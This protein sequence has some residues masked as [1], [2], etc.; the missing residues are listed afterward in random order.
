MRYF[1][2]NLCFYV[3]ITA[4]RDTVVSLITKNTKCFFF[5]IK[6]KQIIFSKL[7]NIKND[8]YLIG[9]LNGL[10]QMINLQMDYK[11]KYGLGQMENE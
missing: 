4:L 6:F 3:F 7:F 8:L 5:F 1:L 10:I 9:Y 2:I 11:I